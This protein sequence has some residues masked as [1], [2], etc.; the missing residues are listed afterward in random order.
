[1][2][3]LLNRIFNVLSSMKLTMICLSAA[4]VLVFAGTLA[5]VQLGIAQWSAGRPAAAI[6]SLPRHFL[7]VALG[8]Q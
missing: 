8:V 7:H 6:A 5:Q 4:M 2:K 1:M 3:S